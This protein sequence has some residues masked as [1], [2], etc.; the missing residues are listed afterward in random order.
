MVGAFVDAFVG[1]TAGA[2]AGA[3]AGATGG[4]LGAADGATNV[5]AGGFTGG[6]GLA[7]TAGRTGTGS[8]FGGA[9]ANGS[10]TFAAALGGTTTAMVAAATAAP[11]AA[12]PA[13]A[14]PVTVVRPAPEGSAEVAA[15][16]A[17]PTSGDGVARGEGV[18]LNARGSATGCEPI[19]VGLAAMGAAAISP[20]CER[21]WAPSTGRGFESKSK[22]KPITPA[23][24]NTKAPISL[25]RVLVLMPPVASVASAALLRGAFA[26]A[27]AGRDLVK[28]KRM[29]GG[30]QGQ[31]K[32]N[33]GPVLRAVHPIEAAPLSTPHRR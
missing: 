22:G 26:S 14:A 16:A 33:A 8:S 17:A 23:T 9:G 15:L 6:P 32:F 5:V 27:W 24:N 4:G 19:F 11:V 18:S 13:T 10:V 12:A 21:A 31:E 28:G 2:A 3:T 1:A 7:S 29:R 25:R 20:D 30:V